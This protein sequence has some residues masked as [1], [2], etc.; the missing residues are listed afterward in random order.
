MEILILVEAWLN[1]LSTF[2]MKID[3]KETRLEGLPLWN[4]RSPRNLTE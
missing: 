2:V 4:K 3:L 1:Y